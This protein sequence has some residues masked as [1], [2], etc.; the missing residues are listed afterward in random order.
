MERVKII[1]RD[2]DGRIAKGFCQDFSPANP[3]FHLV[4][5]EPGAAE[6]ATRVQVKDLK[7]VYFVWDFEG[8]SQYKKCIQSAG[9]QRP[10]GRK[11]EVTFADG[12]VLSGQ[13]WD[14]TGNA[15][16]FSSS[17]QILGATI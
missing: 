4:S 16:D 13:A 12:E 10:A 5:V 11:M 9:E 15:L 1:V 2:A 6:Q 3:Q 7:A 8:N 17:L 14:T